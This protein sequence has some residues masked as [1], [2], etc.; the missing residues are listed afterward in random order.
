[1]LA[2]I[3]YTQEFEERLSKFDDINK[4]IIHLLTL[5]DIFEETPTF[6][7]ALNDLPPLRDL[8]GGA[9]ENFR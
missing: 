4:F 7:K 3:G 9:W 2:G 8:G 5:G 1:M 6:K